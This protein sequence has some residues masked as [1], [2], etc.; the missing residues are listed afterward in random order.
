MSAEITV[1]FH[2][3]LRLS[4]SDERNLPTKKSGAFQGILDNIK[5]AGLPTAS[6]RWGLEYVGVLD[7][8]KKE[9]IF[10]AIVYWCNHG[11]LPYKTLWLN[12]SA[13]WQ[14]GAVPPPHATKPH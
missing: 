8:P 2:I 10:C 7:L 5:D 9:K 14:E 6:L 1:V 12:D 13:K 3:D 4:P 11:G